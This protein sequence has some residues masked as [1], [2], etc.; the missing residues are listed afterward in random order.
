MANKA[1]KAPKAPKAPSSI[2]PK[3]EYSRLL[4]VKNKYGKVFEVTREH[5]DSY[6][7]DLTIVDA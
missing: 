2:T 7:S 5:Y 6:Q 1:T 4:K 3:K